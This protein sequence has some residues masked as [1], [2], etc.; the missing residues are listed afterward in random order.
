GLGA[1]QI[2]SGLSFTFDGIPDTLMTNL[3]VIAIVTVLFMLSATTGVDRGIRYLSWA[4]IV[5]AIALMFFIFSIGSTVQMMES[6]STTLGNYLQKLPSMTFNM[7]AF[8]GDREFL[9]S[10]TLFYW[11][12]WIGWSPFVGTFIARV[13]RGRTI[14]EFIIGVTAVPVLFSAFWFSVFG[15]A[16]ISIIWLPRILTNVSSDYRYCSNFDFFFLYYFSRLWYIRACY[17]NNG[18]EIKPNYKSK[19]YLGNYPCRN[20]FRFIMVRWTRCS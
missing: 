6:F 16:G 8:V 7:N 14:R 17:V 4:N 9:N 1:K 19:S 2:T 20:C 11:S 13:S 15:L 3:I 12:W 18:R 5:L 10:W